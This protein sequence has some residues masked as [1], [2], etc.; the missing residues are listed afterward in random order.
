MVR[1]TATAASPGISASNDGI[2]RVLE[3][4][5]RR[6]D[7]V[8]LRG[9]RS[10][11]AHDIDA[12]DFGE[13]FKL[14]KNVRDPDQ[15][16]NYLYY[17]FQPLY[18][19]LIA[20][21]FRDGR[22]QFAVRSLEGI[23]DASRVYLTGYYMGQPD[24]GLLREGMRRIEPDIGRLGKE[25]RYRTKFRNIDNNRIYPDSILSF[26]R[27]FLEHAI[28]GKIK[29]PDY[30]IGCACGASEIAMPLA[31][32]L[33]TGVGFLR[34]SK[35]RSDTKV[36]VVQEQRPAIQQKVQG[37]DVVC[38]EDYVCT[39]IS[40]GKVMEMTSSYN[41]SSVLG[42]SVAFSSEGTYVRNIV[43]RPEFKL[44]VMGDRR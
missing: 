44:F 21:T 30:V 42:A 11:G 24:I 12:R 26:L 17:G 29:T 36:H 34:R 9:A 20:G 19:S 40:L 23:I 13:W 4:S 3:S 32:L 41:A 39:S 27:Q 6:L 38:I 25:T 16:R 1:R 33:D 15:A 28:D 18:D 43:N 35:R 7:G 37:K 22:R 14:A 10:Y 31:G 8:R 2:R 5:M